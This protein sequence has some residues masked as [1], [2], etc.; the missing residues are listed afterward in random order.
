MRNDKK[1]K[2]DRKLAESAKFFGFKHVG[3]HQF[4]CGNFEVDLSAS[5]NTKEAVAYH[6]AKAVKGFVVATK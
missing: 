6:I 2:L 4:R 3:S 1:F 5:D